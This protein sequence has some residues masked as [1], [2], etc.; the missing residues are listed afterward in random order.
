M[1]DGLLRGRVRVLAL[2]AFLGSAVP[3]FSAEPATRDDIAALQREL[4]QLRSDFG[5]REEVARYRKEVEESRR[6]ARPVTGLD[7]VHDNV[8]WIAIGIAGLAFAGAWVWSNRHSD[9]LRY[10]QALAELLVEAIKRDGAPA[11]AEALTRRVESLANE[12]ADVVTTIQK[13]PRPT[14]AAPSSGGSGQP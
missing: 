4:A 13:M 9:S 11:A 8:P 10:R 12:L 3:V 7:A 14:P 5:L 6:P 2:A 1:D